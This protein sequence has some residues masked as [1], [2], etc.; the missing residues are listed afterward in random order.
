MNKMTETRKPDVS[1]HSLEE[2][3]GEK[4][5]G[6]VQAM[7]GAG[8]TGLYHML[9][10]EF[11]RP[12]ITITLEETRGNQVAAARLLG[13]NRNTLRKKISE[14]GIT[15]ARRRGRPP[16]IEVESTPALRQRESTA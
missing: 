14:L 5:R 11:E 2:L 16:R 6:F 7:A 10:S 4:V 15:V 8:Q 3:V 12:L 13:I 1:Q 9:L